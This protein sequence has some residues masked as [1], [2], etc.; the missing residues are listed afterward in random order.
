RNPTAFLATLR[1]RHG[2]AFLLELFGFRLFFVFSPDGLRSLYELPEETASFT[3]ATRTLIGLK[4]PR[5]LLEGD[6]GLFRHL[7]TAERMDGFL[8]QMQAAAQEAVERLGAS[9]EFEVFRHMKRLVHQIG[10]RCWVG[11]EAASPRYFD[12][13]VA[14][15]ER[16]DP[17][18][19]F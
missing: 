11:H 4:L 15:F 18:E 10:F 16:L 1:A 8:T 7:F 13:L 14:L 9:G 6:L 3:E 19:A 5:E 17:E 12:R 2:N